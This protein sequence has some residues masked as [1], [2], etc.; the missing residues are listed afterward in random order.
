MRGYRSGSG[1]TLRRVTVPPPCSVLRRDI[2]REREI[3]RER[4]KE[5][6]R[7]RLKKTERER[8]RRERVAISLWGV[9][10]RVAG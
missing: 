3:E 5:R 1:N 7:E 8:E 9:G 10:C 2:Y 4:E 6:G